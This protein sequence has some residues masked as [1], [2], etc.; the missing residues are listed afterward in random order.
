MAS[1]RAAL[2]RSSPPSGG[3]RGTWDGIGRSVEVIGSRITRSAGPL[4]NSSSEMTTAGRRPAC[5]WPMVGARFTSQT[6]PRRGGLLNPGALSSLSFFLAVPKSPH[7]IR[8]DRRRAR[9]PIRPARPASLPN[10]GSVARPRNRDLQPPGTAAGAAL[11][12]PPPGRYEVAVLRHARFSSALRAS[13]RRSVPSSAASTHRIRI[14]IHSC[15]PRL[16]AFLE[17]G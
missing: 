13:L 8:E 7:R 16:A 3:D 11:P 2:S 4:L 6:S 17:A 9:N 12:P 5:S 1:Q 10:P 14:R 15:G